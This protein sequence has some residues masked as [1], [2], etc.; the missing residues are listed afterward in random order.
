MAKAERRHE[1][2]VNTHGQSLRLI[3]SWSTGLVPAVIA[4]FC[5]GG[6][7]FLATSGQLLGWFIWAISGAAVTLFIYGKLS[8]ISSLILSQGG[9]SLHD[10]TN[11]SSYRWSD[12]ESF[13]ISRDIFYRN[14]VFSL[15]A[16]GEKRLKPGGIFGSDCLVINSA[17]QRRLPDEYGLGVEHLKSLMS[18]WRER[19]T[20]RK[21]PV[22][23]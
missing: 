15:S 7:G 3:S 11:T 19:Y 6:G 10:G 22:R 2:E 16:A 4:L 13:S 20:E 9:F 23:I 18:Q 1:A 5:F 14:V 8:K 21:D 12:I 17:Y